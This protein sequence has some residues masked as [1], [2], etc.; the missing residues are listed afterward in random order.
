MYSFPIS[1]LWVYVIVVMFHFMN[2]TAIAVVIDFKELV[3]TVVFSIMGLFWEDCVWSYRVSRKSG[4]IGQFIADFFFCCKFKPCLWCCWV[5]R[6]VSGLFCLFEAGIRAR[7]LRNST[8]LSFRRLLIPWHVIPDLRDTLYFAIGPYYI[9]PKC[10][11][12]L[13]HNVLYYATQNCA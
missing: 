8:D 6:N 11:D 9:N 4:I 5:R 2:Y 10:L 12:V 7:S 1:Y 3:G 13:D